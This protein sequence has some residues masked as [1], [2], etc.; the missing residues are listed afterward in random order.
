MCQDEGMSRKKPSFWQGLVQAIREQ[1][2]SP[3][4]ARYVQVSYRDLDMRDRPLLLTKG[5][6]FIWDL[7]SPPVVGAWVYVPG[8]DGVATGVVVKVG[9][10]VTAKNSRLKRVLGVI[11]D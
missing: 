2:A 11:A 8:N 4:V 3:P 9:K 5:Y 6:S 1:K 10:E 7:P